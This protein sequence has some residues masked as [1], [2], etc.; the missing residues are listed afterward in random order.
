MAE[1]RLSAPA[2]AQI[3][4]ILDWSQEKFGERTAERYAALLVKAMEDVADHPRQKSVLWKRVAA[5]EVG[6]YHIRHSRDHVSDP[7][8][9]VGDPRHHLIFRIGRDGI[10]DILGFIHERMLFNRALRRL[11]SVNRD[12][13]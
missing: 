1:Y 10:A 9:Q 5:G 12:N 2:E 8:G 11:L 4:E 6:V 3:E 13:R 7:P